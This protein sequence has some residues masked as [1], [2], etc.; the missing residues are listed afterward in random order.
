M[1]FKPIKREDGRSVIYHRKA[2]WDKWKLTPRGASFTRRA[3]ALAWITR[4][5]KQTAKAI[6]DTLAHQVLRSSPFCA[7]IKIN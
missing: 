5:E 7:N 6:R 3:S 1:E 2:N 4:L